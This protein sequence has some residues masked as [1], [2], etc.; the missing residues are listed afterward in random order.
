[1][2]LV[3]RHS[4]ITLALSA[5]V[6]AE[7][8]WGEGET[9]QDCQDLTDNDG[10]GKVDC[11][12]AGCMGFDVCFPHGDDVAAPASPAITESSPSGQ[13]V[14]I[15]EFMTSNRAAVEEPDG[16]GSYPDWIELYNPTGASL[17]LAGYTATDDLAVPDRFELPELSIEAGGYLLLWADGQEAEAGHLGFKLAAAS[18]D[19][20]LFDSA[21][22]EVA[23]LSYDQQF[24]DVSASRTADAATSW[25]FDSS[26]TPGEANAP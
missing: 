16:S 2:A 5:C 24:T 17:S 15:N 10:D 6:P 4:L 14:V 1:M 23:A 22:A 25:M 3:V 9:L 8:G 21:G 11:D 19:I 13:I 26:P 18:G 7:S 12:D 20:G